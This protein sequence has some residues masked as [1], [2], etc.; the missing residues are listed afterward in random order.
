[1][2]RTLKDGGLVV[3]L[4]TGKGK[5]NIYPRTGYEGTEGKTMCSSTLPSTLALDGGVWSTPR[6]GRFTRGKDTV[7]IVLE[8]GWA[9]GPFWTGAEHLAPTEIQFPDHPA[10]SE[11]LY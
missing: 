1:V 5:G 11:L 3:F 9:P 10:C 8:A 2:S 7:P 4:S 6:P